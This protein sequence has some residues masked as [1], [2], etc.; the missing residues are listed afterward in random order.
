[1]VD[2]KIKGERKRERTDSERYWA[3]ESEKQKMVKKTK[4][5]K[6]KNINDKKKKKAWKKD[7]NKSITYIRS[8][9]ERE[10]ART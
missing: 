2:K 5:R 1:M 8:Q 6:K 10:D 3:R 4:K 9:S 7:S